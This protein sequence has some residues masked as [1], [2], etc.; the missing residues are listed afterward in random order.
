MDGFQPIKRRSLGSRKRRFMPFGDFNE[1]LENGDSTNEGSG[2]FSSSPPFDATL[3]SLHPESGYEAVD[4]EEN[5]EEPRLDDDVTDDSENQFEVK[6]KLFEDDDETTFEDST[7]T[8]PNYDA[9]LVLNQEERRSSVQITDKPEER[10]E[11]TAQAI[12]QEENPE[13]SNLDNDIREE[14][15]SENQSDVTQR[16]LEED[17]EIVSEESISMVAFPK[18]NVSISRGTTEKTKATTI[19]QTEVRTVSTQPTPM[20]SNSEGCKQVCFLDFFL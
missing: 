16:L 7:S 17:E 18:E 9:R 8:I 19:S 15:T 12:D 6:L 5:R 2:E 1:E 4:Q 14:S 20:S 11:W 10:D 3:T 13:E